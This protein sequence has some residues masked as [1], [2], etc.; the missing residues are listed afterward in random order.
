[1]T[2]LE[3]FKW[4]LQQF[5]NNEAITF[6][7]SELWEKLERAKSRYLEVY[8]GSQYTELIERFNRARYEI[9]AIDYIINQKGGVIK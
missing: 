9:A 6:S 1:M 2:D 3:A 7:N 4:Y 8:K 5:N